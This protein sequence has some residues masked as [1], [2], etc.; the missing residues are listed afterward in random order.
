V[1]AE[2]RVGCRVEVVAVE[3]RRA[4]VDVSFLIVDLGLGFDFLQK[5]A[6]L[7]PLDIERNFF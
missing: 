5:T 2:D 3:R 4:L 6:F 7:A 1:L